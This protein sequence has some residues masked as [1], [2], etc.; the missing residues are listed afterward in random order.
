[1]P[2]KILVT[3]GAGYLGSVICEMAHTRGYEAI[4]FD[5]GWFGLDHLI[6]WIKPDNIIIDDIRNISKHKISDLYAVVHMAGLSNDPQAMAYPDQN[7]AINTDGTR[8]VGEYCA[9]NNLLMTFASSASVYGYVEGYECLE[10]E[11]LNPKSYYA[12]SKVKAEAELLKIR[13]STGDKFRPWIF[14]QA[15]CMGYQK[16]GRFRSDLVVNT[17]LRDGWFKG[18]IHLMGG[19]E[20]WR[21]LV[22]IKDIA[23]AHLYVLNPVFEHVQSDRIYNISHKNCRISEVGNYLA[24]LLKKNY[25]KTANVIPHYPA[26]EFRNY[27]MSTAK[28]A[29]EL[30]FFANIGLQE[31]C[32]D[33]CDFFM[34]VPTDFN[35]YDV[36][37]KNL[38]WLRNIVAFESI[39]KKA[40]SVF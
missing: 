22:N 37:Y 13:Q 15:T 18:E 27:A 14:R 32:F 2:K 25:N 30:N 19:G 6:H 36:R 4:C 7:F 28:A 40:G 1:M 38:E 24:Y 35:P 29:N 16:G 5:K 8:I 17:M 11:T 12:E 3:G 20:C 33:I 31:T 9:E 21:P 10:S 23:R 39:L 26:D 34:K